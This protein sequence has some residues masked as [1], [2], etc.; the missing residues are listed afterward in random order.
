MDLG[1]LLFSRCVVMA[2]L[3]EAVHN[4]NSGQTSCSCP[5]IPS[6]NLTK[7]PLKNESFNVNFTFRYTCID[8][9]VRKAGTSNL[10]KCKL[11]IIN[12]AQDCYWWMPPVRLQCIP[13]PKKQ[14]PSTMATAA[15]TTSQQMTQSVSTSASQAAET[16]STVTTSPGLQ[17]PSNHSQAA[18]TSQQMTQSVST[19]ASQA[20]ETG[21]TVTT[22]PGLQVPSNHSQA[23]DT[24]IQQMTQSVST[25]ASQ[26]AETGSTV[27]TSPG[28]QVRSNH[29]Q[30]AASTSQ[31]MT[32]SVSTSASQAAE[33][34]STVTISPGLQV[35]SNHSQEFSGK[36]A[37]AVALPSLV[38]ICACIGILYYK[39]RNNRNNRRGTEEEIPMNSPSCGPP[40]AL[41]TGL[42]SSHVLLPQNQSSSDD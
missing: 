1:S 8:G 18:A 30:A 3:I 40:A 9:Y 10:T 32:Q 35:R 24:T 7:P 37:T 29:S 4:S 16:G 26:A 36:T 14:L 31:Q 19:S 12:G 39:S 34:G 6:W 41:D 2:F 42:S 22:S 38:I 11:R 21:S 33:T 17:V 23:A 28:L 5:E 27:T 20:A 13:D 15:D 25:S